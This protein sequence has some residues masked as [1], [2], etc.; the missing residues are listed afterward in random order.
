MGDEIH[1]LLELGR[2]LIDPS[3]PASSRLAVIVVFGVPLGLLAFLVP[4][5]LR[6]A[7]RE[8]P[9]FLG[10]FRDDFRGLAAA[11]RSARDQRRRRLDAARWAMPARVPQ[12]G[13][14]AAPIDAR[15]YEPKVVEPDLRAVESEPEGP[16]I[17][18]AALRYLKKTYPNARSLESV[19]GARH[20]DDVDVAFYEGDLPR[21]ASFRADGEFQAAEETLTVDLLAPLLRDVVRS[22]HPAGA[23]IEVRR[24][25]TPGDDYY[26]T[27]SAAGGKTLVVRVEPSGRIRGRG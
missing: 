21:Y 1:S 9:A 10:G 19:T 16:V 4:Y 2:W 3:V 24:Y 15:R 22:A 20:P 13:E 5:I 18:E 26:E 12:P 11:R 27:E 6:T 7:M 25:R 17:P 14:E 8:A 23:E